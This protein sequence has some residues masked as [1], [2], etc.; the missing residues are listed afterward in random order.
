MTSPNAIQLAYLNPAVSKNSL[1][2]ILE[3][4]DQKNADVIVI[5]EFTPELVSEVIKFKSRFPHQFLLPKSDALGKA[6]LSK[7]ELANKSE[8]ELLE[9][10]L[11]SLYTTNSRNDSFQIMISSHL[12]L[13]TMMSYRKL[14]QFLEELSIKLVNAYQNFILVANFN[15]VPWSR[16][17]RKFRDVSGLITS[18]R[19]NADRNSKAGNLDILNTT[20]MEVMYSKNLECSYFEVILDSHD[21]PLGIIGRYQLKFKF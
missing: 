15:L 19:D 10:T 1:E 17:L 21:N 13:I 6:I 7:F 8:Y 4:V 11:I 16:E 18:R 20:T 9:N 2:E 14:N 3:L 12:P 5:E